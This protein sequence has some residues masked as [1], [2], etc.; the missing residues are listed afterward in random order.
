MRWLA[1]G[2]WAGFLLTLILDPEKGI[3]IALAGFF[4]VLIV[5][6]VGHRIWLRRR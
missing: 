3:K 1:R 4:I 6:D 2:A 5:L